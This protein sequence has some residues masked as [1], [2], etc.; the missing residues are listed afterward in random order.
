MVNV[1][2]KIP[3]P[4]KWFGSKATGIAVA[5]VAAG[6]IVLWKKNLDQ[7]SSKRY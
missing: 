5:A 2:S 7:L 4:A 6:I 1:L 3:P